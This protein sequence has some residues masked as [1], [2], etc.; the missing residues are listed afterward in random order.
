[1]ILEIATSIVD[2]FD[3]NNLVHLQAYRTLQQTGVWPKGFLPENI[4]FPIAW[5]A[6]IAFKLA[7]CFMG[8][9]LKAG[10]A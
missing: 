5:H 6:S 2:W 1:M 9:K 8:E 3:C 4:I 10:K 7:D